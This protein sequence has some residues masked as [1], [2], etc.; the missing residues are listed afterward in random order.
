MR[1]EVRHAEAR[2]DRLAHFDPVT[3]QLNRHA[4]NG[5]LQRMAARLQDDARGRIAMIM[6]DLDN[7]K[8][9]NDSLGHHVG[10]ELLKQ[11]SQR[12]YDILRRSDAVFRIGGD[13]FAITLYPVSSAL[14]VMAVTDR[15]LETFQ[16]P[17]MLDMHE[18]HASASCGIS[19]FPDDAADLQVL[20]SNAD[21]AMYRAKHNGKNS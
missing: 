3:G 15:I 4:F 16:Q 19:I 5:H 2:L 14:E 10:D 8:V 17:F 6:L 12:L 18:V 20:A 11:V 21:A 7:F 1:R 9:V 13:E